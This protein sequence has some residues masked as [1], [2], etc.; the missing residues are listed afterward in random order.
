M[1]FIKKIFTLRE[2]NISSHGESKQHPG[3][4][5]TDKPELHEPAGQV[6]T[7]PADAPPTDA[8]GL[9]QNQPQSPRPPL[10]LASG[11]LF[12]W[13]LFALLLAG[14]YLAYI[15][16][17][18]FFNTLI[19]AV[20]FAAIF[21]PLYSRLR[22]AMRGRGSLAASCML[23]IVA[24]LVILP[25]IIFITGL[26]PQARQ[27]TT[28]VTQWMS[29]THVD[30]FNAYLNPIFDWLNE[31]VPFLEITPA[32]VKTSLVNLSR[33]VG[34]AFFTY[35]TSML[36]QTLTFFLHFMLFLLALFFFLKD[37][38]VMVERIKFLS[39][40]REKQEERII[41]NLRKVSRAVLVGGF[42]VAALQGFVGG[43]GFAFVGI[44]ALFWGTVMVFASLVPLV[45][46]GLVWVPAVLYL[47]IMGQWKSALFLTLWCGVLVS[48]IDSFL[49]PLI[50][51][52]ASGIPV[53]FL[54]LAILGG[55]QAFGVFGLL[56]GP[57]IL[58]FAVAMLGIY[59]EEYSAELEHR[60]H[61]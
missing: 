39:P 41:Q 33:T 32:G 61:N 58:T 36:G 34:Q 44:P 37:G 55:L 17:A 6:A 50:M 13:F 22:A 46:T 31:H 7:P 9:C 11:H 42:L 23:V 24:L 12:S 47:C 51:R 56:Y 25:L 21:Y 54:F 29:G 15:L 20:V 59:G 4:S 14:L 52:D 1:S 60:H 8:P 45:G 26:I 53:L 35:S 27:T 19:L 3:D 38:A 2:R 18:P 10:Q 49:R 5:V 57:L 48:S 43:L 16:L 28:A 40:L 30:E